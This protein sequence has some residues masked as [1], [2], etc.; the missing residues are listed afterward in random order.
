MGAKSKT[1]V[2]LEVCASE[3]FL[4]CSHEAQALYLHVNVNAD[5]YGVVVNPSRLLRGGGFSTEAFGR[6]YIDRLRSEVQRTP[7]DGD[8]HSPLLDDEQARQ[9]EPN[10][11]RVP[12]RTIKGVRV[13]RR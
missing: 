3:P 12:R 11:K 13:Y 8:S 4:D 6:T 7:W 9:G 1:M 10:N 2:S 5:S